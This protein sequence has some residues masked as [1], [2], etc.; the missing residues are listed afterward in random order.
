M[1]EIPAGFSPHKS[2]VLIVSQLLAFD[3]LSK[4]LSE[5]LTSF[6]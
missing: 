6:G 3:N 1:T 2:P 5:S 4:A